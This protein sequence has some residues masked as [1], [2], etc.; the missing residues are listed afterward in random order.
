MKVTTIFVCGSKCRSV[1]CL[2]ISCRCSLANSSM[3]T[4]VSCM[5]IRGSLC[6]E[7]AKASLQQEL[8]ESL[9][10]NAEVARLQGTVADVESQLSA[11]TSQL[12]D[13]RQQ[14]TLEKAKN[15]SSQKHNEVFIKLTP[16]TLIFTNSTLIHRSVFISA[17]H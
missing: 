6:A 13:S 16:L 17:F 3:S 10:N 7:S 5:F 4:I 14:L 12:N 8:T 11:V 1:I 15:K 2:S 9:T